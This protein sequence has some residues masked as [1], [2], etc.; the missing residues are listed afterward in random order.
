MGLPAELAVI[1]ALVLLNGVL[2]GAEIA[3]VTVRASRIEELAARGRRGARA[4]QRLR[5]D[6][7]RFLATVQVGI[8]V[9]GV[10]AGAFGG[11]TLGGDLALVL[12]RVPGLERHAAPLAFVLAVALITYLSI[13]VGEL[14][15]KSM[16]LRHSEAYAL[17][18]ARPLEL[19]ARV[20]RPAV[21]LL[22]ASSNAILRLFGDRTD[23]LE[24]R[25]SA[26]ELRKLVDRASRQGEVHPQAGE[27]ASRALE[28]SGLTAADVMVHRRFLVAV[29]FDATTEE[30]REVFLR[31][32]HKRIPVYRGSLE[33]MV[34]YL[35]LRDVY[36]SLL[37]D[38][39]DVSGLVR[40]A[41]LVPETLGASDLLRQM[42]RTRQHLALVVDEHGGVAGLVT[43]EDLLEELVGEIDSEH[44]TAYERIRRDPDGA[45]TVLGETPLRDVNRALRVHIA[46]PREG[47]TLNA[48]LV[49]LAGGRIPE[50]GERF[51]ASD[52]TQLEVL[53]A[54]ARRVRQ[55]RVGGAAPQPLS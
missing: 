23:F 54:S 15:P 44:S 36:R 29:A 34:G 8:T 27:I 20:G 30:V 37:E 49:E 7:E 19:L 28:L 6:P 33:D 46:S 14:V 31:S 47:S 10:T 52:G 21:W 3:L 53:E 17:I 24:A 38:D 2:A 9:V 39:D 18:V 42:L 12:E 11:A 43:L 25:L 48:L 5:A 40:P 50:R 55:V 13:V 35:S 41:Q 32:G 45:A 22:S 4:V 26:E 16:A 1:V 51:A